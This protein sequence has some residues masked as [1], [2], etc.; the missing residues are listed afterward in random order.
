MVIRNTFVQ[1]TLSI[2]HATLVLVVLGIRIAIKAWR[3]GGLPDAETPRVDSQIFTPSG[4]LATDREKEVLAQWRAAG[5][6][7]SGEHLDHSEHA[8]RLAAS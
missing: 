3:A 6:D 7:A 1:G 2:V 5:L 4:F 8:H